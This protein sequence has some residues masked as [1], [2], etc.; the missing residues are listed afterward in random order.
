MNSLKKTL[1]RA[2]LA[3]AALGCA[4]VSTTPANAAIIY[5]GTRTVGTATVTLSITTNGDIG[6]ILTSDIIDWSITMVDGA[7]NAVLEGPGG[8][9]NST[10]FVAGLALTAS[11]TELLFPFDVAGNTALG[12]IANSGD[13]RYCVMTLD[14]NCNGFGNALL[15]SAREGVRFNGFQGSVVARSGTATLARAEVIRVPVP[16]PAT[17]ALMLVGFGLTGLGL[18]RRRAR[19]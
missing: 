16:E 14:T 8:L 17:W 7:K 13:D 12:F 15:P 5:N 2:M 19:N 10:V 4:L 1:V 9:N 18:R 3:G 6:T 11:A